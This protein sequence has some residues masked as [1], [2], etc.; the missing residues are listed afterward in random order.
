MVENATLLA[1][2]MGVVAVIVMVVS[3]IAGKSAKNSNDFM[4]AGGKMPFFLVTATLLAT[5]VCGGTVM[6]GAGIAFT[7]GMQATIP[8]PFGAALCLIA[9]GAFF[10]GVIR[11]TGAISAGSVYRNRYGAVGAAVASVCMIPTF[12]FFAGSQIAALAKLVQVVLGGDFI[13]IVLIAGAFIIIHTWL[14]G[15]TAVAWTDFIQIGLL[16]LGVIILFPIA[17]NHLNDMGGHQAAVDLMGEDFFSFGLRGDYSF[18]GIATYLALWIGTSTGAIPG[19]DLI[20]RGLISKTPKVARWAGITAGIIMAI[21]GILVVFLGG[22]ANLFVEK[23]MF[24]AAEVATINADSEMLVLIMSTKLLPSWLVALF[25]TGVMGAIV[26]SADSALFAP[27]TI[28][29]NDIIRSYFDKKKKP[30]KDKSLT[31]WTQFAVLGLG[32]A[33]TAL[34]A[35]T[36]SVFTLMVMGFTIQTILF[37]PLLLALYWKGANKAGGVAG[38]I[39]GMAIIVIMMLTQWTVEPGPYWLVV[40]LP[41]GAGVLVQVVVSKLTAKKYPPVALTHADGS[42]VKWPELLKNTPASVIHS[43][44]VE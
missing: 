34:G 14:G 28:V 44:E 21:I 17:L 42:V 26:S 2:V 22:W 31:T 12:V 41:M 30:Y 5:F 10:L 37:F 35:A 32:I 39:T 1:V 36:Q 24:T 27:A 23:G 38:M 29:S 19:A 15:I 20:Q 3:V 11:K 7:D 25:F 33:A 4:V 40:F 13:W 16:I 43:S 18:A 9:G 6:G 8:D